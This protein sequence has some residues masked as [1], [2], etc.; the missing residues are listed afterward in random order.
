MVVPHF[1]CAICGQL[2]PQYSLRAASARRSWNIIM[3]SCLARHGIISLEMAESV[4]TQVSKNSDK[5]KGL[6]CKEHYIDVAV[7]L[8]KEVEQLG[9]DFP[10]LGL[11]EVPRKVLNDFIGILR[12]CGKLLDSELDLHVKDIMDFYL[13]CLYKFHTKIREKQL[14]LKREVQG[15]ASPMGDHPASDSVVPTKKQK[16]VPPEPSV[17]SH[18]NT[19]RRYNC[20]LCEVPRFETEVRDTS[21]NHKHNLILFSCLV[22]ENSIDDQFAKNVYESISRKRKRLCKE[23]Y[24]QTCLFIANEMK[25]VSGIVPIHGLDCVPMECWQ[26]FFERIQAYSNQ[27]DKSLVIEPIDVIRFYD[28]C[29][30]TF[31]T[32]DGWNAFVQ[33]SNYGDVMMPSTSGLFQSQADCKTEPAESLAI[34][35]TTLLASSRVKTEP[36]GEAYD[37]PDCLENPTPCTQEKQ[38]FRICAICSTRRAKLECSSTSARRDMDLTLIGCLVVNNSLDLESAKTAWSKFVDK[39]KA[40]CNEHYI[41]AATAIRN[42]IID[43]PGS[44]PPKLPDKKWIDLLVKIQAHGALIDSRVVLS[45]D[46]LREFYNECVTKFLPQESLQNEFPRCKQEPLEES[47]PMLCNP[48][49]QPPCTADQLIGTGTDS[50]ENSGDVPSDEHS[51]D[52]RANKKRQAGILGNS[53]KG[54]S[55]DESRHRNRVCTLCGAIRVEEETRSGSSNVRQNMVLIS[56]LL[57]CNVAEME[58][59]KPTYQGILNTRRR[60]CKLH[61]IQ[62]ANWIG[63]EIEKTWGKFPIHGLFGVPRKT[64]TILLARLQY[65]VDALG[66]EERLG[67]EDLA[68]FYGDCLSKYRHMDGWKAE[69]LQNKEEIAQASLEAIQTMLADPTPAACPSNVV[70]KPTKPTKRTAQK[71]SSEGKSG[72]QVVCALCGVSWPHLEMRCSAFDRPQN[73]ML[74]S[75]LVVKGTLDLSEAVRLYEALEVQRKY[76][77]KSHYREAAAFINQDLRLNRNLSNNADAVASGDNIDLL[78][79]LQAVVQALDEQIALRTCDLVRFGGE[80]MP[81]YRKQAAK[82]KSGKVLE[83]VLN[84]FLNEEAP[85]PPDTPAERDIKTEPGTSGN[86]LDTVF[87]DE[88]QGRTYCCTLCGVFQPMK[89]LCMTTVPYSRTLIMLSYSLKTNIITPDLARKFYEDIF[90]SRQRV[91]K[92]H[93]QETA[94]Y[95]SNYVV[96]ACGSIPQGGLSDVPKNVLDG[97]LEDIHKHLSDVEDFMSLED[98]DITSFLDFCPSKAHFK[99]T[100][101]GQSEGKDVEPQ[102]E[103]NDLEMHEFCNSL[104]ETSSREGSPDDEEHWLKDEE[105]PKGDDGGKTDSDWEAESKI[106]VPVFRPPQKPGFATFGDKSVPMDMVKFAI[107]F[108]RSGRRGYRSQSSMWNRFRWI[109]SEYDMEKLRKIEKKVG[110]KAL[111]KYKKLVAKRL[112]EDKIAQREKTSFFTVKSEDGESS[113]KDTNSANALDVPGTEKISSLRRTFCAVCGTQD[114]PEK[115]RRPPPEAEYTIVLLASLCM[116]ELIEPAQTKNVYS[117]PIGVLGRYICQDH[118]IQAAGHLGRKAKAVWGKFPQEGLC[119]LPEEIL[120]KLV[121]DLRVH[122]ENI[123]VS[124]WKYVHSIRF[125]SLEALFEGE[126]EQKGDLREGVNAA[127]RPPHSAIVEERSLSPEDMKS[128]C[129]YYLDI[130]FTGEAASGGGQEE[131]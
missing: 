2:R 24:N 79:R 8:G 125:D 111:E 95:I 49:G 21:K 27:F 128:S 98:G 37:Q 58:S 116:Q 72:R 77:C 18:V 92:R 56:C 31:R 44:S 47:D 127:D 122:S 130:Q 86:H 69:A 83:Q 109:R 20:A 26:N 67:V 102:D 38:A 93:F 17:T 59:A 34:D 73:A 36:E 81:N 112:L 115:M 123:D 35:A 126:Y 43:V 61:Y 48:V 104:G 4:Y 60:L 52:I 62:A 28:D 9:G 97:L 129:K 101:I 64:L 82:K 121:K 120:C 19:P 39:R 42:E 51:N 100:R 75:S 71:K 57:L 50:N 80:F 46:C 13:D 12:A 63:E 14:G 94:A 118:Y 78:S 40:V 113:A 108:Y 1:L 11:S 16:S 10:F 74:L 3:L 29:L 65:C 106:P 131:R 32:C 7:F 99:D 91:C 45:T 41:E 103:D 89:E 117:K 68:W 124:P 53:Q 84:S 55:H 119:N 110:E 107:A 54:S 22:I 87:V 105:D 96:E 23:H 88:F 85:P 6:F 90:R 30:A 66:V 70:Q 114:V 76:L 15:D 5:L 25:Q 33:S